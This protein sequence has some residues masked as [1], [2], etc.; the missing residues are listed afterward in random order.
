MT[1]QK[2]KEDHYKEAAM[3][4]N[5]SDNALQ[6]SEKDG[7]V[8]F[9]LARGILTF[10][11]SSV[12]F[13]D[14]V[15]IHQMATRSMED[16]L[17]CFDAV[18]S[19][20]PTNVI[21]LLGKVRPTRGSNIVSNTGVHIHSNRHAFFMLDGNI[22]RLSNF[23]KMSY[24]TTQNVNQTPEL[25][26]DCAVGLWIKRPEQRLLGNGAWKWYGLIP[27][28]ASMRSHPLSRFRTPTTLLPNF[29]SVWR[30]STRVRTRGYRKMSGDRLS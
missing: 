18:L 5:A 25:V 20:Q 1:S 23:S 9:L 17:R 29:C 10:A 21:A 27:L 28:I 2:I 13:V 11:P 3:C 7:G 30:P 14:F 24:D 16:A 26:S 8:L 6:Q 15:G 22:L 12:S 19:T 4:I